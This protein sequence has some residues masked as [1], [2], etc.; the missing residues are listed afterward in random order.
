MGTV[1]GF[2]SSDLRSKVDAL[3]ELRQADTENYLSVRK[4]VLHER[5]NDLLDKKDFVSGA[6]TLLRLHR[7]LDFLR[8]FLRAVG[9]LQEEEGTCKSCQ[10]AYGNTLAEH[11]PWLIR[12]GATMAMHALPTKFNLL[13]K[14][15]ADA[16]KAIFTLPDMLTATDK[17]YD[18]IQSLYTEFELQGLP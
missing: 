8:E 4:M 9:E 11:H 12:K 5:N 17:V 3:L 7:G 13:K 2:V 15:C 16:E 10:V 14:V 18:R 1:F 6:R